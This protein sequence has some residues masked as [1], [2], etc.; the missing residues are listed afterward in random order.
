MN[1]HI[2][3]NKLKNFIINS[4]QLF[5]KQTRLSSF[6]SSEYRAYNEPVLDFKR[7]SPERKSLSQKLQVSIKGLIDSKD[8]LFD[9]PIVIGDKEIR[10][11]NTK[12]QLI[13]FDHKLK[14]A[15]FYHADKKIIEEAIKN[16]LEARAQWEST[17][18]EYRAEILLRAA[19]L[20]SNEKRTDI[21]AATMLGQGKT[22]YQAE[23]DAACELVDFLRFNVQFLLDLLKYKPL[24]VSTHTTNNMNLRGLEGFCAAISPFNFTAIGGNLCTA[25]ALMGNTVVWKPSDTAVLSSYILY[26]V[27]LLNIKFIKLK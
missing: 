16:C 3:V 2:R 27:I 20:I 1:N 8:A 6:N 22:V 19:D 11:S 13:P 23:I 4:K 10:T 12:Y 5:L 24:D 17:S 25:P 9:V 26:K 18:F 14:L 7:D 21:L 15:R